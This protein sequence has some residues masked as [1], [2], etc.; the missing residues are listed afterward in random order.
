MKSVLMVIF[1]TAQ[2]LH[3]Q[4]FEQEPPIIAP[5]VWRYPVAYLGLIGDMIVFQ[6]LPGVL[7][8]VTDKV[9][10]LTSFKNTFSIGFID[11]S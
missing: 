7:N 2:S 4:E 1:L 3:A 10:R 8:N 5:W 6:L 11:Q 9:R